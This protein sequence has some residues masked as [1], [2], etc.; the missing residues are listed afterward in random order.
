MRLSVIIPAYNSAGTITRAIDSVLAQIRPIDEIVVVDDGSTDNTAEIVHRYGDAVRYFH[1]GNTGISGAMNLGIEQAVGEWIA[2]LAADDE[3]LPGFITSHAKL[4][5]DK[6]AVRWTYCHYEKVTPTGRLEMQV[7]RIVREEIDHEGSLSY[8]RAELAGFNFGACGFTIQRCVFSEL[9]KYDLTMRNG[10]DGDMWRRIALRYPRV[11]V[12]G[13]ARW[14]YYCDNPKSLH[15][16]GRRC[17]DLQMKSVCSGMRDA[18]RIG[19][20]VVNDY[21][22]YAKRLIM[23]DLMRQAA[24][25]CSITSDVIEDAKGLFPPTIRER[26]LLAILRLLPKWAAMRVVDR[27]VC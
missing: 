18:R 2:V 10:Q 24:R 4:I 9:G 8:F 17:R 20:P 14:R 3:W 25:D 16:E 23:R 26:G 22:P 7:P 13:G 12:C 19:P 27:L 1:Q 21:G 6:P 15:H 5:S 11:A